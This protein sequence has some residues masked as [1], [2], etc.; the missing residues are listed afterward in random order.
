VLTLADTT[1]ALVGVRYGSL[2]FQTLDGRKSAEGSL[3]FFVTAFLSVHVPVLLMTETGRLESLLLGVIIGLLV[4]LLESVAWRGLDNLMVPLGTLVF[5]DVYLD[6]PAE[7]L[8]WRVAAVIALV[9]FTLLWRRRSSMDDSALIGGALFG[10]A[11]ILLGGWAWLLPPLA[12]F[13]THSILWPRSSKPPIHSVGAVL[14]VTGVGLVCL[15][16][17]TPYPWHGWLWVYTASFAAHLAMVGVSYMLY[18]K[19]V[20]RS[21]RIRYLLASGAM[22][23][24]MTF[25]PVCLIYLSRLR[26]SDLLVIGFT[27]LVTTYIA[28]VVFDM[29]RPWLYGGHSSPERI[30]GTAFAIAVLVAVVNALTFYLW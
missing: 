17:K 27:L 5:L 29:L 10:F 21:H 9:V 19:L 4:M 13:L 14:S 28:A 8:A 22:G 1:A 2:H 26:T 11:A 15:L 23:W 30:H 20:R 25:L 3:A 16:L 24:G 12:L 6:A 7:A 18:D